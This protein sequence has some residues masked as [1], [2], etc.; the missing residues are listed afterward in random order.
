MTIGKELSEG[1][2]S[3]KVEGR[4]DTNTSQELESELKLEGVTEVVFDFSRLE[5]ISSAGLRVLMLAQKTM[6]ACGG[7]VLVASPNAVVKSVLDITGMSS[8]FTII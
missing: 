3:L 7:K 2:L 6:T 4:L 1:K 5:Y 8:I